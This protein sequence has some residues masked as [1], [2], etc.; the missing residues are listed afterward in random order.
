MV[1]GP[2]G[3]SLAPGGSIWM[4][5]SVNDGDAYPAPGSASPGSASP[6]SAAPGSIGAEGDEPAALPDRL[7]LAHPFFAALPDAYFRISPHTRQPVFVLQLGNADTTLSL[8]GICR[9]FSIVPDSNDGRMLDLVDK[10]L[11]HVRVIRPGD[12]L[13]REI[14]T[15]EAS[16]EITE[17]H[18]AIALQRLTL[19]LTSWASGSER[20]ITDI[21]QLAQL[22]DDPAMPARMAEATAAAAEALGRPEAEVKQGITRLTEELAFFE[23]LRSRFGRLQRTTE[24]MRLARRT[25]ARDRVHAETIDRICRLTSLATRQ[26]ADT[27]EQADAQTGEIIA[28][29]RNEAAQRNFIRTL[30]DRLHG[31][32]SAW[33]DVIPGWEKLD[34]R[35]PYPPARADGRDLPL[36]RAALHAGG[37]VGARDAARRQRRRPDEERR[38]LVRLARALAAQQPQG[39]FQRNGR[40]RLR[41]HSFSAWTA[42]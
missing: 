37:G 3:V 31:C 22:A 21:Q 26:L 33:E 8:R 23:A 36:P 35:H 9:E 28:A 20:V 25:V 5:A 34:A 4:V 6:G 2:P 13:P 42:V 14:L 10:A 7:T 30:R 17:E 24:R 1:K 40:I 38:H 27:I 32:L 19:Q 11:Q 29:L 12:A 15:G 16:W 18:R 41:L 39:S